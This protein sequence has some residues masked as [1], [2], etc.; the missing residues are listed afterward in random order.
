MSSTLTNPL[1][2]AY[3][4]G[5]R[6]AA[7]DLPRARQNE[8]V[9]DI[10]EHLSEAI[11]PGAS[12]AEVLTALDRLGEADQIVE[13]ERERT[14]LRPTRAGWFEWAT[15]T[16]LLI[17]GV[18]LPILGWLIGVVFL[19]GSRVWTMRDKLIGTLLVPGGLTAAVFLFFFGV[20]S[21]STTCFSDSRIDPATGHLLSTAEHC[22][23]GPSMLALVLSILL[24][25]GLV[26]TPISTAVYLTRRAQRYRSTTA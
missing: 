15:V 24:F 26:I 17:G 9:H 16:L 18:V 25:A 10:E 23:G 2:R 11:P 13:E 8:L 3:L 19:W 5:L 22:T 1:V 7:R 21:S 4:D 20:S 6:S 12:D 14:G